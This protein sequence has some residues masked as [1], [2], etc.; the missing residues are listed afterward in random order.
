MMEYENLLKKAGFDDK[1][2]KVYLA[3]LELRSAPTSVI[4]QRAGIV[5][6]TCYGIL[7]EL[8]QK[9]LAS[10]SEKAGGVTKFNVDNPGLLQNYI[11]S[12]KQVFED[13]EK[14]IVKI[15]PDLKKLQ[16][17]YTIKPQIEYFEGKAGVESALE[18]VIPDLKV[19]GKNKIPVLIHGATNALVE[20]W[21]QFPQYAEKRRKLGVKVKMFVWDEVKVPAMAEIHRKGYEIKKIPPKY[22]YEAGSQIME[23]KL[24][25]FDFNNMITVVI[26]NKPLVQMMRVFF[27]MT[28]DKIG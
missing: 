22:A 8:V 3:A 26:K 14:D 25:L 17:D 5:R 24:I 4:A 11:K 7:E 18:S 13:L 12:R 23:D 28:W 27:E 16:K 15:I 9:G 21:P 10:K 20:A 19:M 1:E 6:S 2:T